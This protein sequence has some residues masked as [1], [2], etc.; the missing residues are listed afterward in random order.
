MT[1]DTAAAEDW[2]MAVSMFIDDISSLVG[3][4]WGGNVLELVLH[5]ATSEA[6]LVVVVEGGSEEVEEATA[7]F[8]N[9]DDDELFL[10][11][12]VTIFIEA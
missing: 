2:A 7:F 4:G 8:A 9:G 6:V 1:E 3:G 12:L 10:L 11:L 5:V